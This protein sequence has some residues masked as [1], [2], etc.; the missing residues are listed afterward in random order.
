[1]SAP[2]EDLMG[3]EMTEHPDEEISVV[4]SDDRPSEDRV[5]PRDESRG[6]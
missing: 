4:V 1:M 6:L 5:E 2:L 3:N